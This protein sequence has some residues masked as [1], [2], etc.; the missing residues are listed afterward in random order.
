MR[1]RK[2]H[3]ARK[4]ISMDVE[5]YLDP[6]RIFD[7]STNMEMKIDMVQTEAAVRALAALAQEHRLAGFRLLVQAGNVGLPAGSLAERLGVPPSSLSFHLAQLTQAGLI[8]QQRRGRSLIY[9]ADYAAMSGLMAFLSENCC[10]SGLA[11]CAAET[12]CLPPETTER[13]IA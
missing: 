3:R 6:S 4:I 10:G 2:L 7:I 12:G 13:K 11:A 1:Q 8:V 5:I 9:R